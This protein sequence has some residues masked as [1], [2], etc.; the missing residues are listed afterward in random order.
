MPI[1]CLVRVKTITILT[2]AV[3]IIIMLGARVKM[4]KRIKTCTPWVNSCGVFAPCMPILIFGKAIAAKL[5]AFVIKKRQNAPKIFIKFLKPL[6]IN[7]FLFYCSKTPMRLNL[8]YLSSFNSCTFIFLY[9]S[10]DFKRTLLS[11][12]AMAQGS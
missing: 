3:V 9:S 11:S 2:N 10:S 12:S 7:F 8:L 1:A 5:W 6:P 4:V